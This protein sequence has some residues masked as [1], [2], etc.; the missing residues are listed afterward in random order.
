VRLSVLPQNS[1]QAFFYLST[2]PVFQP[3]C[4]KVST[5]TF[6]DFRCLQVLGLILRNHSADFWEFTL[7]TIFDGKS[8]TTRAICWGLTLKEQDELRKLIT[9]AKETG[10]HFLFLPILLV[11]VGINKLARFVENRRQ[12]SS[13]V[14]E[15]LGMDDYFDK[16]QTNG[17]LGERIHL[18]DLN[19]A[20]ERLTSLSQSVVRL[21]CYCEAQMRFVLRLESVL[22]E[23]QSGSTST[24]SKDA[25]V[26][27]AFGDRL[28]YLRDSIVSI[29]S[30]V[31]SVQKAISGLV[32]TVSN[33][34]IV[35]NDE[36]R[37]H[38]LGLQSDRPK[39]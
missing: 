2:V 10:N 38:Y 18:L 32:N 6:L 17:T 12:E 37:R 28:S 31:D 20:T 9:P 35:L 3:T 11:D 36:S 1:C 26:N 24:S 23:M 39:R 16:R 25:K 4:R 19:S 30:E 22:K 15:K 13:I 29:Q 21:S 8:K 5:R 33:S 34:S 14:Q 7:I 27:E